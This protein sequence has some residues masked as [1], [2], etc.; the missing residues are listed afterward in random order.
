[1][2]TTTLQELPQ[3]LRSALSETTLISAV[4]AA[5]QRTL[6]C[7]TTQPAHTFTPR[8]RVLLSLLTYCYAAD[9]LSS[10]DVEDGCRTDLAL[11][12][13]CAGSIPTAR[14]V[15]G[16][17]R[18]STPALTRSLSETFHETAPSH[19]SSHLH[20]MAVHRIRQA[21]NLDHM[22]LDV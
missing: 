19:D 10:Q 7:P 16:F 20:T 8:G 12:Y 9:V 5:V 13:L 22:E 6:D 3:D 2:N 11:R 17:R 15:A 21:I 18:A 1:M 4:F 14:E